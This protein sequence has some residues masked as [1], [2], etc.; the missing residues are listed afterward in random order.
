MAH[1]TGSNSAPRIIV[2]NFQIVISGLSFLWSCLNVKMPSENTQEMTGSCI[3]FCVKYILVFYCN[4]DESALILVFCCQ[5]TLKIFFESEYHKISNAGTIL[6]PRFIVFFICKTQ[7]GMLRYFSHSSHCYISNVLPAFLIPFTITQFI[8]TSECITRMFF[9][10]LSI[11]QITEW[12]IAH[13]IIQAL[14]P[15]Q[16]FSWLFWHIRTH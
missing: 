7:L 2:D 13:G 11:F 14:M 9:P 1:R 10:Y 4:R 12:N 8:L 3:P 16:C 5:I 6:V 15:G